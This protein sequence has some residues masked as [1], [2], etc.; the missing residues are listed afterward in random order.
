MRSHFYEL[1]RRYYARAIMPLFLL[2]YC[3]FLLIYQAAG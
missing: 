1:M 3:A 2:L